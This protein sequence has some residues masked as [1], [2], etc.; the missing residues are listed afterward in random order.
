MGNPLKFLGRMA[1]FAVKAR[2][3]ANA[4]KQSED[5]L[6]L[7]QQLAIKYAHADEDARRL[8]TEVDEALAAWRDVV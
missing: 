8:K 2:K 4:V 6:E 1:K 5:V 3:I 7:A